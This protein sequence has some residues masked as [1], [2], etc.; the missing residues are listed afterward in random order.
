MVGPY[1]CDWSRIAGSVDRAAAPPLKHSGA[2][3]KRPT[4]GERADD[5]LAPFA[6]LGVVPDVDPFHVEQHV[7]R[8]VRRVIRQPLQIAGNGK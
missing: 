6:D 4:P 3:G 7:L 8:N 2:T 1:H 5:T